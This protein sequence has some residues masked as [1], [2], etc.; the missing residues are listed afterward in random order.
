MALDTAAVLGPP[1]A[2]AR[3]LDTAVA[4][5]PP[6]ARAEDRALAA[7]VVFA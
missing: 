7:A 2:W 4:E 6:S 3:A 1:R 5:A